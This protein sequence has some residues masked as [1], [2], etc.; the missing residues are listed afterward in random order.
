MSSW[1]LWWAAVICEDI[2]DSLPQA[3]DGTDGLK[4]AHRA[5][6]ETC[7]RCQAEL[8]QYRPPT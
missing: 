7:L 1:V 6:V 8:V 4:A 2:A 5:H 3:V